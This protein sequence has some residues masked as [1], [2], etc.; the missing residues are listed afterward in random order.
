[1]MSWVQPTALGFDLDLDLDLALALAFALS[2]PDSVFSHL[3]GFQP[4]TYIHTYMYAT[5]TP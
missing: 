2:L 5:H 4:S 1:M 3:Y